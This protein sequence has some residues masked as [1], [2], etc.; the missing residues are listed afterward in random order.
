MSACCSDY[1]NEYFAAAWGKKLSP[2]VSRKPNKLHFVICSVLRALK[3]SK[4]CRIYSLWLRHLV[5]NK[6]V[7]VVLS[8]RCLLCI[9]NHPSLTGL[10]KGCS[11]SPDS[12]TPEFSK[13]Y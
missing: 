8:Q 11:F 10:S 9:E 2:E 5:L 7:K 4:V 13:D 1:K 12:F 6:M 3:C